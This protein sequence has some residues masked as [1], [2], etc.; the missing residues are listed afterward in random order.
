MFEMEPYKH[1]DHLLEDSDRLV[2]RSEEFHGK[3]K[4]LLS[5]SERDFQETSKYGEVPPIFFP[6]LRQI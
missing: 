5:S 2:V 6:R 4:A 3:E 1:P